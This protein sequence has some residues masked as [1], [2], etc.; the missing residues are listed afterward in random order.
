[1]SEAGGPYGYEVLK[2]W[3]SLSPDARENVM[4]T[5]ERYRG[6]PYGEH[7]IKWNSHH[8]GSELAPT[9]MEDLAFYWRAWWTHRGALSRAVEPSR[10]MSRL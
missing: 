9:L 6:R 1:M 3:N 4:R 10:R 2:T 5:L 8:T 7:F